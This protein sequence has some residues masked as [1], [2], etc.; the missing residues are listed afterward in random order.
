MDWLRVKRQVKGERKVARN[1]ICI[2]YICI[3][4]LILPGNKQ[5][6]GLENEATVNSQSIFTPFLTPWFPTV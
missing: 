3:H 2:F 4:L 1:H 6:P 5:F